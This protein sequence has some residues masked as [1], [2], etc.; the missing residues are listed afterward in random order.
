VLDTDLE[1]ARLRAKQAEKEAKR[2]KRIAKEAERAERFTAVNTT[3]V[4]KVD[5]K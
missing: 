3:T 5:E 1:A 2:A 4:T